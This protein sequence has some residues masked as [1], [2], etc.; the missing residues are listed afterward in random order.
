MFGILYGLFMGVS[1]V[2]RLVKNT[3]E[4]EVRKEHAKK[5]YDHTYYDKKGKRR[6]LD[7]GRWVHSVVRNED[8][9]LE[10]VETHQ[11]YRNFSQEQRNKI[12]E[13]RKLKAIQNGRTVYVYEDRNPR[14]YRE[15]ELWKGTLYEDVNTGD[16]YVERSRYVNEE[17]RI[18]EVR[19][20][21]NIKNGLFVRKTD[22]QL[23]ED[24]KWKEKLDTLVDRKF[25]FVSMIARRKQMTKEQFDERL[26]KEINRE[27][28]YILNRYISDDKFDEFI[29]KENIKQAEYKANG[30]NKL[31]YDYSERRQYS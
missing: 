28:N 15:S 9:I 1:G 8:R 31:Y 5:Y 13:D 14:L 25:D 12:R 16:H 4:E 19:M 17:Y 3:Y 29:Y 30:S 20:Y 11:I 26:N 22:I 2:G 24:I 6:L 7:N 27:R 18:G 10:D 21:V 23:E